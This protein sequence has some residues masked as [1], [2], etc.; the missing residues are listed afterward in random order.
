MLSIKGLC[1]ALVL[2]LWLVVPA[3]ATTPSVVGN[4]YCNT[5]ASTCTGNFSSGVS[6]GSSILVVGAYG[7][8]SG[9]ITLSV[10]D[11]A[12]NCTTYTTT[13]DTANSPAFHTQ[14]F[15]VCATTTTALT[16]SST[17]TVTT[18]G[19]AGLFNVGMVKIGG[20]NALAFPA[21]V[22]NFATGSGTSGTTLPT[23]P[24]T[25]TLTWGTEDAFA[26]VTWYNGHTTDAISWGNGFSAVACWPASASNRPS[27]CLG[28][29]TVSS[30]TVT[31]AATVTNSGAGYI[32]S[33]IM[34][35]NSGTMSCIVP[36]G[37]M[38]GA[39]GGRRC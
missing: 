34:I 15:A 6:A 31:P 2:W 30:G 1:A 19:A 28:R 21:A 5:A 22:S 20:A 24:T 39:G 3:H 9:T 38:M 35:A 25:P 29:A 26:L 14:F 13:H 17:I 4:V 12:G 7:A 8:Y 10:A 16:T 11:S 27:V 33:A 32:A 37:L 36:G 23:M 18:T